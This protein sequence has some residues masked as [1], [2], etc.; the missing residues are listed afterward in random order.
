MKQQYLLAIS[1]DITEIEEE[2]NRL[3]RQGYSPQPM[4][5]TVVRAEKSQNDITR[6]THRY[7]VPC[8]YTGGANEQAD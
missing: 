1:T 2:V 4:Q 3:I 8:V 6:F 7:I 5:V